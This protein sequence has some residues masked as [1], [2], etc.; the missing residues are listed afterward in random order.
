[1]DTYS[2]DLDDLGLGLLGRGLILDQRRARGP[3]LAR[4]LVVEEMGVSRARDDAADREALDRGVAN[5]A[6][7]ALVVDRP[8]DVRMRSDARSFAGSSR[9]SLELEYKAL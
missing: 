6:E 3:V 9:E 4:L 1:M 7:D 8:V 2:L 5:G